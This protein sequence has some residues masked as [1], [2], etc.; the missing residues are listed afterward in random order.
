MRVYTKGGR[1]RSRDH[2][3]DLQSPQIDRGER[4]GRERERNEGR[5]G[6]NH[7]R[8]ETAQREG[9]K[10][11][12]GEGERGKGEEGKG[13]GG[14]RSKKERREHTGGRER[15][16]GRE[17]IAFFVH[18]NS[19]TI[20]QALLFSKSSSHHQQMPQELYRLRIKFTSL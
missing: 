17:T 7:E 1:E 12:G 19:I 8:K 9:E 4:E 10:W 13:E 20:H 6:E 11:R 3:A 15:G 14:D 18:T 5:E 2:E 16:R